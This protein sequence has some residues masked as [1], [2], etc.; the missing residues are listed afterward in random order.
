V[1]GVVVF[2]Y[3]L[4]YLLDSLLLKFGYFTYGDTTPAYFLIFG[5]GYIVV[6]IYL[7]RGAD[8]ILRF[9]FPLL[10]GDEDEEDEEG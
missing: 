8:S 4:T 5:L 3:G 9:A 10:N 2:L 6:G 7:M 1:A